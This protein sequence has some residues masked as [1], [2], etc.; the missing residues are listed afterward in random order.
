MLTL[1]L[2][3]LT[4]AASSMWVARQ[5]GPYPANGGKWKVFYNPNNPLRRERN[6]KR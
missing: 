6:G 5:M 2:T 1:T 4:H 3:V